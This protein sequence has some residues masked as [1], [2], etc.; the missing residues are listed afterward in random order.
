MGILIKPVIT[1]KSSAQSEDRNCF[2]FVVRRDANK[3]EIKQAVEE[4][5]GVHVEKVRTALMPGKSK[6]RYTKSGLSRGNT[7]AYK[8]ALVQ[9]QSGE[10][11]D[12]YSNI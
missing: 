11:I 12:L 10:T 2:A 4:L 6:S 7:G 5:Y 1:E 8:K 9:V 3:I